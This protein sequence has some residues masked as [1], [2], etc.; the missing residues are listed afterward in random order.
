MNDGGPGDVDA[1]TVR[2]WIDQGQDVTVIDVRGV[3]GLLVVLGT[4]MSL[5]V[6]PMLVPALGIGAGLTFSALTN[7]CAMGR[8]LCVLPYNRGPADPS[9]ER[10]V[11]HLPERTA[12]SPP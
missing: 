3:P 12:A 11:A 5:W 10:V 9:T 6:P 7:T 1:T 8:L 4:L 2:T